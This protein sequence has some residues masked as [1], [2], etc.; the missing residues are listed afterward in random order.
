VRDELQEYRF[1]FLRRPDQLSSEQQRQLAGLLAS[2]AG[3][4]LQVVRSFVE[5]WQSIWWS[6]GGERRTLE[7]AQQRF[8]A[9]QSREAFT[10]V[11]PLG[12]VQRRL[13]RRFEKLSQFLRDPRWEATNNGAERMGRAFRHRQGPH[14]NL[15]TEETIEGAIVVAACQRKEAVLAPAREPFH[16]CQRGRRPRVEFAVAWAA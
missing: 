12:H 8:E 3:D 2:P 6:D 5:E 10:S 7:E 9:W 16:T 14:F 13:K 15:R 4:R 1:L 11:A